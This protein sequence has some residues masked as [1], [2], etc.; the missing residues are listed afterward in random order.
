MDTSQDQQARQVLLELT[1]L[2]H[3]S[4]TNWA[5]TTSGTRD[6]DPRPTGDSNPVADQYAAAYADAAGDVSRQRVL[7][8]AREELARWR[9]HGITRAPGETQAA[10]D[11]RMVREGEGWTVDEVSRH[12][13][14]TRR[15]VRKIC[16][17]HGVAIDYRDVL[18]PLGAVSRAS[19]AKAMRDADTSQADIAAAL[20]ISQPTVSRLLKVA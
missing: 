6:R 9:G 14:C 4:V 16:S 2:S 3:G 11:A 7:H 20:G 18:S 8:E 13:H 12:F 1:L 19:M 17:E 5:P 10:K 15:H